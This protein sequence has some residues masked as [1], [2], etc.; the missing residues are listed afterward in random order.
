MAVIKTAHLSCYLTVG[1]RQ[2]Q[3]AL[4]IISIH[5]CRDLPVTVLSHSTSM[6]LCNPALLLR[7]AEDVPEIPI[8]GEGISK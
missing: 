4:I 8:G 5:W 3:L 2:R 7:E 1:S 6:L